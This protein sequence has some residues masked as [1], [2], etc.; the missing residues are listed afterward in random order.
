MMESGSQQQQQGGGEQRRPRLLS[1][2]DHLL[3][4]VFTFLPARDCA[5]LALTCTRLAEIARSTHAFAGIQCEIDAHRGYD[6]GLPVR[7]RMQAV[8]ITG[9]TEKTLAVF[10]KLTEA[11]HHPV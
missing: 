7:L 5:H 11:L 2:P 9:T 1:L 3:A 4:H 6:V 10:S 8:Q